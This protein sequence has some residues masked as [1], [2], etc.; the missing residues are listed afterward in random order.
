LINDLA[1]GQVE[2][3]ALRGYRRYETAGETSNEA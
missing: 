3:E 1:R 2:R